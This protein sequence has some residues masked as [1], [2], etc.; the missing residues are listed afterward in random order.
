MNRFPLRAPIG[1]AIALILLA[2]SLL[3]YTATTDDLGLKLVMAKKALAQETAVRS[4][5]SIQEIVNN[6]PAR[7]D[8]IIL[9]EMSF[10]PVYDVAEVS[11]IDN[12]RIDHNAVFKTMAMG[13][14]H[15]AS[16]LDLG[17]NKDSAKKVLLL[18][19]KIESHLKGFSRVIFLVEQDQLAAALKDISKTLPKGIDAATLISRINGLTNDLSDVT[20]GNVL[21]NRLIAAAL[22]KNGKKTT[23]SISESDIRD[24]NR[25]LQKLLD[26]VARKT[27]SLLAEDLAERSRQMLGG[28]VVFVEQYKYSTRPDIPKLSLPSAQHLSEAGIDASFADLRKLLSAGGLSVSVNLQAMVTG[29]EPE[30]KK[31]YRLFVTDRYSYK[32]KN[33]FIYAVLAIAACALLLAWHLALFLRGLS[34]NRHRLDQ[35]RHNY[36]SIK[37]N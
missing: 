5:S 16:T 36:G 9:R 31:N 35:L 26:Q 13:T 2:L 18:K 1:H 23:I 20:D 19:Q 25:D 7:G 12:D 17:N 15:G 32:E 11:Y 29:F 27:D 37:N 14:S 28:Q 34:G 3:I 30:E 22:E 33:R 8:E 6:P 4:Y 24:I 10:S 21:M